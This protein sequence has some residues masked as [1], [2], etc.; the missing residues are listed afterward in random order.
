MTYNESCETEGEY[1]YHFLHCNIMKNKIK[2]DN[3]RVN[4]QVLILKIRKVTFRSLI[5]VSNN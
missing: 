4:L 3:I 5:V 2:D 1:R